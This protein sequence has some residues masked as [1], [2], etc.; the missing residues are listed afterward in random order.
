[1]KPNTSGGGG[2]GRVIDKSSD[3]GGTD[4]WAV[5][6]AQ[7]SRLN[8]AAD[9]TSATLFRS[10]AN[11]V[12]AGVHRTYGLSR[13]GTGSAECK[14]VRDGVQIS[15]DTYVVVPPATAITAAIGNWNA[16]DDRMFDGI[17]D[18][19]MVWERDL[20]VLEHSQIHVDPFQMIHNPFESNA[21]LAGT[22]AAATGNPFWYYQMINA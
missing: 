5:Y 16:A 6:M 17:I 13:S 18:Y 9:N 8:F 15:T 19:V 21:L 22:G 20:S 10:G 2:F 3:G 12:T 1:M 4:G 14:W 7:T 11:F